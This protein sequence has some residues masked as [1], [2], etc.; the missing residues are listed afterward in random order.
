MDAINNNKYI[1]LIVAPSGTGKTEFCKILQEKHKLRSIASYTTRM[2]RYEG[3]T[4]HTFVTKEEFDSL[5]NKVAY[6]LY[7]DNEYCATQEQVDNADLYVIDVAGVE[8]FKRTYKGTKK[9]IVVKLC[10]SDLTRIIRMLQRGD[11]L[12]AVIK[13]LEV[14]EVEFADFK[15]DLS[16]NAERSLKTMVLTF[17]IKTRLMPLSLL[18]NKI[19]R[20]IDRFDDNIQSLM[21]G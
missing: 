12:D 20:R 6:T 18:L 10:A 11:S 17:L 4:G 7:D 19:S 13:R 3:E 1:F 9:A 14:D 21:E 5:P 2:R 15:Y 16:I 8:Y